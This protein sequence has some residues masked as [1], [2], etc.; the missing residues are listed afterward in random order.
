MTIQSFKKNLKIFE[1]PTV[2][3]PR[4]GG[5]SKV[6]SF[7]AGLRFTKRLMLEVRD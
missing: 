7:R 1:F 3:H 5:F 6:P 2:E 4:L